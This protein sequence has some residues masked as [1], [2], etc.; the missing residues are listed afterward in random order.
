MTSKAD[1]EKSLK[2]L[3]DK[4]AMGQQVLIL[5]ESTAL[6]LQT[7]LE[8]LDLDEKITIELIEF[9]HE[10]IRCNNL[11]IKLFLPSTS[12][13]SHLME[14]WRLVRD[15]LEVLDKDKK[16]FLVRYKLTL[17]DFQTKDAEW[18]NP[19]EVEDLEF[20]QEMSPTQREELIKTCN[21]NDNARGDD[22]VRDLTKGLGC[23]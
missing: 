7:R 11:L 3:S 1:I 13:R 23:Y 14:Q 16:N 12:D 2:E 21:M 8:S 9:I 15:K 20:E 22:N 17:A 5:K 19:S 4:L 6:W 10:Q 18:S